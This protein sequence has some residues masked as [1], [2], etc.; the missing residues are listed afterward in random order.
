MW[1]NNLPTETGKA[2]NSTDR[3]MSL[4]T[5]AFSPYSMGCIDARKVFSTL[6]WLRHGK[7]R[8]QRRL[9]GA[10]LHPR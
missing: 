10:T 2:V 9:G 8:D 6:S 3:G 7:R 4:L 5:D 1:S